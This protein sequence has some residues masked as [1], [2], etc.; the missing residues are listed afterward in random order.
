MTALPDSLKDMTAEVGTRNVTFGYCYKLAE[1]IAESVESRPSKN[2]GSNTLSRNGNEEVANSFDSDG[3][4]SS[5]VTRDGT[6]KTTIRL[7]ENSDSTSLLSS[8]MIMWADMI[9]QDQKAAFSRWAQLPMNQWNS[10][11]K[12]MFALAMMHHVHNL[13]ASDSLTPEGK[14][15]LLGSLSANSLPAL[16]KPLTRE[17]RGIFQSILPLQK[18]NA[19]CATILLFA[20]CSMITCAVHWLA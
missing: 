11:H 6:G 7:N 1:E 20:F 2:A 13:A 10:G 5:T 19:G 18:A 17:V 8:S 9:S 14:L 3:K 12:K 16:P 4:P 15:M